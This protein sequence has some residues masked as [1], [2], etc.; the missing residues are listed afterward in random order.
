MFVKVCGITRECDAAVAV[1]CGASAVGFIFWPNSRR[2]IEP[3][4]ARAIVRTLPPFVTPVGVFVNESAAHVNQVAAAVGL[5]AVQLHGD[6]SPDML[7]QIACP[8]VKATGR[9]DPVA[10]GRWPGRVTVLVDA[11]DRVNHGGTGMKADWTAA[12]AL[13]RLRRTILAGGIR[14]ENVVEAV[15]T[16]QP[17]GVDV[18]SGVEDAPGIKNPERIRALFEALRG[19]PRG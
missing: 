14:P 3:A 11:D 19:V 10:L 18:S 16:V 7:E 15:T 2:W 8:V 5:G 4:A 12:A 13:A 6:E 1:E 9:V 17:F